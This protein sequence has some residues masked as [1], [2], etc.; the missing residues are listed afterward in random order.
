[1]NINLSKF[2]ALLACPFVN[3]FYKGI[4]LIATYR[5]ARLYNTISES[6]RAVKDNRENIVIFPE[7]SD[8]GYFKHLKSFFAGF[9]VLAQ[10]LFKNGIDVP[11][12]V[13]YYKTET[14]EYVFDAPVL[15]S[16]LKA[17]YGSKAE[18]ASHLLD[19]CNAIGDLDLQQKTA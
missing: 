5:D 17:A 6:V 13:A 1:M 2:V 19:R 8:K 16:E 14:R 4:R 12:Y 3:L 9:V 10:Q 11:V 15:F 7:N 18:I